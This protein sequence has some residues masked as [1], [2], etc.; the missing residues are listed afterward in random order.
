MTSDE[1]KEFRT[2]VREELE[3]KGVD[4]FEFHQAMVQYEHPWSVIA[5]KDARVDDEG[6]LIAK[7][8]YDW[9]DADGADPRHS[10]LRALQEL[11]L[12]E[13][14]QW[15]DLKQQTRKKYEQWRSEVKSAEEAQAAQPQW[16]RMHTKALKAYSSVPPTAS[17]AL[18]ALLLSMIVAPG[19]AHW[20]SSM[21]GA[22]QELH[23]TAAELNTTK[24]RLDGVTSVLDQEVARLV[25]RVVLGAAAEGVWLGRVCLSLE[26]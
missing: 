18:I 25:A 17:M 15:R 13:P 3:K 1:K 12:G 20:V 7:R 2:F 22:R 11:I 21:L 24:G 4:V 5:T 9:G 14:S 6:V 26:R 23:H 19:A 8:V 16:R 10:D